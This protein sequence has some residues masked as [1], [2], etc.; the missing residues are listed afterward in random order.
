MIIN[1]KNMIKITAL[2]LLT[3]FSQQ[4]VGQEVLA[5]ENSVDDALIASF[6]FDDPENGI[7]GSGAKAEVQ[8]T[9]VYVGA[10]HGKAAQLSET[11]WLK[12][13]KENGEPL[14]KGQEEITISYNSKP[15]GGNG[16]AFY[17]SNDEKTQTYQRERYIGIADKTSGITVERFNNTGSRPGN[18]LSAPS[19]TSWK[20]IDLVIK[21]NSTTIFVDGVQKDTK[22]STYKLSDILSETGGII[23]LGKANWGSGEYYKGLIDDVK[24]YSRALSNEEIEAEYQGIAKENLVEIYNQYKDTEKGNYTESTWNNIT[25]ALTN[26]EEVLGQE[27]STA[28]IVNKAISQIEQAFQYATNVQETVNYS[29]IGIPVGETWLDTEGN[30]IQAHGG[31]FLQQTASDGEPIYYWV[32]EN[33][34]H[35]S[36][37]FFAVSLYSSRD[38]VNWQ[39]EGNILDQFTETVPGAELGLQYNKVERPKLLY[40]EKT[41]KYVLWG[42]WEDG[43]GYSSSQIMVA[44]A[45]KAE[46][47]Y[48]FQGHWRP[49]GTERNWRSNNGWFTDEEY[50]KTGEREQ[51]P[52]SEQTD[53][54]KYGYVSRDFTVFQEGDNA[55]LIS[56]EGHS[57]RIHRLNDRFDDVD[58]TTYPFSPSDIKDSTFES[59]NFY[60]GVG[61]EAPA[62]VNVENDGYYLVTSGQ[63]GWLPNQS[64][65]GYTNDITNP[66][67]WSPL[68]GSDGL[69]LERA[70][71]G[72]NS[73]YYSQSTNIMTITKQDGTKQYVYMGDRWNSKQLGDSRYVWLPLTIDTENHTASMKYSTGWKLNVESG[74]I[75]LPEGISLVSQGKNAYGSNADD[76]DRP[77]ELANDGYE[78]NLRTSGDN[79]HWYRPGDAPFDYTVD[80]EE[81]YD[82]SRMDI[83]FRLY[84]GSEMYYQYKVYGSNN[85]KDWVEIADESKN[86]W[87]GFKSTP[88]QGE[89]RY[90][91]L[92]VSAIKRVNDNSNGN[93]ANGLVEVQVYAKTEMKN[94]SKEELETL[95]QEE[96]NSRNEKDYTEESWNVYQEALKL[97]K[98]ILDDEKAKQ[99]MVDD[100]K[101][102]VEKAILGLEKRVL[103]EQITINSN[104]L[105]T[106]KAGT[107]KQLSVTILP[108]KATNSSIKWTIQKEDIV[109]INENNVLVAKKAGTTKIIV[110]TPSGGED[111]ITI[112]VTK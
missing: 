59:Y 65:V 104:D 93:W 32:G 34:I 47:P 94:V 111:S 108:E 53:P 48:V 55:Y 62:I 28:Q 57:M 107:T 109:T 97:A 60:E 22:D 20:H 66:D 42:H 105:I 27:N 11:F 106:M 70:A 54:Q 30:H 67:G 19:S 41:K 58:F 83:A 92:S 69:I 95:Y 29:E 10:P 76:P 82:L 103:V 44:T 35:N 91:R 21:E 79:T 64:T 112:R 100:A 31:G 26:A 46:G 51:I 23:Q 25:R 96:N 50:F 85:N 68:K 72:N 101:E 33:K 15:D 17:A 78:F 1:P 7:V 110:S 81:T 98:E 63:S 37:N 9:P 8:G 56:S 61:R 99:Q 75:S 12:V 45:D 13:E 52:V 87:A 4:F 77:I 16:W 84:N 2:S 5:S 89:F 38:L 90:V 80:L 18:S 102:Q 74:N 71:L 36:A 6:N 3:L 40:N 43:S 88:L 39:N 73:S 49:G 14:L 24:I 86:T